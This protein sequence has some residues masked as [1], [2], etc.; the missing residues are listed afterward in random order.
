M[1]FYISGELPWEKFNAETDS[2]LFD[3]LRTAKME[4]SIDTLC[5]GVNC[6]RKFWMYVKTLE[7]AQKIDYQKLIEL[8][9]VGDPL[10]EN[11]F[12]FC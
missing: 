4:S 11:C 9:D 8:F 3:K 1:L 6:L 10:L 5:A 2:D 7:P 12:E